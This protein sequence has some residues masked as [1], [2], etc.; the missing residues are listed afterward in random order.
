M[1]VFGRFPLTSPSRQ[2]RQRWFTLPQSPA[3]N[4]LSINGNRGNAGD[5]GF[6]GEMESTLGYLSFWSQRKLKW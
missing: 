5:T 6:V 2:T 4:V 3:G 1:Y